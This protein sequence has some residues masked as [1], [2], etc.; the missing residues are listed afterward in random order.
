MAVAVVVQVHNL[1]GLVGK[2]DIGKALT[3]R[4]ADVG[5]VEV[6][7]LGADDDCS[8]GTRSMALRVHS[9]YRRAPNRPRRAAGSTPRMSGSCALGGLRGVVGRRRL[10]RLG[11]LPTLAW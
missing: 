2:P 4:G 10:Q 6:G 11:A 7:K 9:P 1:A 3:D 8:G 5:E